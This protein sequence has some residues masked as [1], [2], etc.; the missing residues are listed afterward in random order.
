MIKEEYKGYLLQGEGSFAMVVIK[1]LGRGSVPKE[2]RGL[3]TSYAEAKRAV[4]RLE[5]ALEDG[6][7]K[8]TSR[9]K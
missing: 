6:K 9:D 8:R 7:T 1:P 2:L 4:D 3:Y 5:R